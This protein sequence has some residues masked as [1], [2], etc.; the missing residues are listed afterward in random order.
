MNYRNRSAAED[1]IDVLARDLGNLTH[2]DDIVYAVL[3][4]AKHNQLTRDQ[5]LVGMVI[6]LS[7]RAKEAQDL[8]IKQA[9][10]APQTIFIRKET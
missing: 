10:L 3:M 4:Q 5:T 7:A 9:T 6:M 1:E 8:L 2:Q